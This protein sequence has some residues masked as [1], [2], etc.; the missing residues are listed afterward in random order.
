M[1]KWTCKNSVF[2]MFDYGVAMKKILVL[3][4]IVL[5]SLGRYASA[6]G[7]ADT[8]NSTRYKLDEEKTTAYEVREAD[9]EIA[10]TNALELEKAKGL[11]IKNDEPRVV[12]ETTSNGRIEKLVDSEGKV[13]A[14]KT[15]ENDKIVKKVL[16]YYYPNKQLMRK[17]TA[18]D[19][20]KGFY[21]E[22]YYN[23]GKIS[24]QATFINED[25]KIGIEKKYDS[26][27]VLRQEIPWVMDD[28]KKN[29]KTIRSGY[30]T[31]YYPDG[32]IAAVFSVGKNG[33]TI[34]YDTQGFPIKEIEDNQI[35]NFSKE[36]TEQDCRGTAIQ[37]GLEE[38]VELYEDEGD[39]SYNKCGFPYRENFVYEVIKKLEN[40]ETKISYD[41]NG[42][43]RRITLYNEGKKD[44]IEKKYD[45][46]G[47]VTAEINYRDGKKEGYATGYFPT[48]E[49]AFRK[50]YED[51]K[52]VDKL[53][54]YFPTGDVAAEFNYKDG[55]KEG[56]ALVNSPIKATLQFSKGK[57]LNVKNENKTR[58]LVSAL[59]ILKDT[60][61]HC[62][63]LKDSL[64]DMTTLIQDK[65]NSIRSSFVINMPQECSNKDNFVIEK[66]K[67]VCY[68]A[69]HK[70]LSVLPV[71]YKRGE[72]VTEK[73]Y[74]PEGKLIY[75]IPYMK[76]NR[77]GW[78]REY[79]EKEI[80]ISEMYFNQDKLSENA[81]SYYPNGKIKDVITESTDSPHKVLARYKENGELEFS[82]NYKGEEKQTA[83]INDAAN[84]KDIT[85]YYYQGKPDSIRESEINNPYNFTEYNLALGE[86]TVY[87]NNDLV[88]GGKLCQESPAKDVEVITLKRMEDNKSQVKEKEI[89]TENIPGMPKVEDIINSDEKLPEPPVVTAEEAPIVR[90]LSPLDEKEVF[91]DNE[92]KDEMKH[93]LI[94]S[95]EDKRQT[96]LA[97]Q[98]IGPKATPDIE[99]LV[100][101]VQKET[102][103]IGGLRAQDNN[104]SKT[105]KFYYPNGNLRKT[106]KTKGSRTEEIKE[107]SKNGLLLTD[108]MYEQDK[109]IIEKYFGSGEVRRKTQ[110]SYDD[111]AVTAFM[112]REDF[113]DNGKLRYEIKRQPQTMLFTEKTYFPDGKIKSEIVQTG[114]LTFKIKEY[115][116]N[117]DIVKETTQPQSSDIK[118]A[119]DSQALRTYN[120]KGK[121]KTEI[122]FYN[123]GEI[124]VK[125]F[126]ANGSLSQFAYLA[127]DSKLHIEKPELRIIP[128]YR[129]RYWVDYNN[130][131]WIENQ[132]KYSILSIARLNL[133]IATK[134]LE[135]LHVEI[136]APL[137]RLSEKY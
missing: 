129:E 136:P 116:Q 74:T 17:V 7:S 34:F 115:D 28:N 113:Y 82:L 92:L 42:M 35:L 49:V 121:L 123:N 96:E 45:A 118:M 64:I 60:A 80:V 130:P 127:P 39:I 75:E 101:V 103:S 128:S 26:T 120:A 53:T 133:N 43:I 67:M 76:K 94:P 40:R 97:A 1:L 46:N 30:I 44:G 41:E 107:Y 14:E 79:N 111:N 23:N 124:S 98:N 12:T 52:V 9:K 86:Y 56:T 32:Q 126:D 78:A 109:I 104:E 24:S 27:G 15:I 51:G 54:C 66:T 112:M 63:N 21:A 11:D 6:E 29:P 62:L 38:L 59:S 25:N 31:T 19:N 99:Q 73:V 55:L 125:S 100:D 10:S 50:R 71:I 16:N 22:E 77:Q 13:I 108:T 72:Y 137:K 90:D 68:N 47:N 84:G 69:A 89:A 33:K 117:G 65:V 18:L 87:K 88:K 3:T 2:N 105:E 61:E 20:D 106:V 57:M 5:A 83:Y 93:A 110:K 132:D 8:S 58:K 48:R 36:L 85:I 102:V 122:I 4:L 37:L 131:H 119:K 114:A 91:A 81:R 95:E 70:Y 135:E 134:I